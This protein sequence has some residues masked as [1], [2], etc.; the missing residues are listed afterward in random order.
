[1][2]R[3]CC[4]AYISGIFGARKKRCVSDIFLGTVRLQEVKGKKSQ[5]QWPIAE[6]ASYLRGTCGHSLWVGMLGVL[7]I[8]SDHDV[9]DLSAGLKVRCDSEV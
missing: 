2:S 3:K 8:L 7:P 1:V 4:T 5:L 9:Y 6:L